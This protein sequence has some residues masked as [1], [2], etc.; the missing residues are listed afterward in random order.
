MSSASKSSSNAKNR[1]G[2]YSEKEQKIFGA[3]QFYIKEWETICKC[4][5]INEYRSWAFKGELSVCRFRSVCWRV[6]LNIL[7]TD[8]AKV[9]YIFFVYEY[10]IMAFIKF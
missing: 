9:K 6:C 5:D 8:S 2:V 3:S 1:S 10:L 4:R 7:P